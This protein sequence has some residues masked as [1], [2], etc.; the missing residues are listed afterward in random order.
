[1]EVSEELLG[2]K[3]VEAVPVGLLGAVE[4]RELALEHW[5]DEDEVLHAC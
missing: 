2:R 4:Q 3:V 5:E 1:M